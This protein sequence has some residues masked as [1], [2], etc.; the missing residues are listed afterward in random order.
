MTKLFFYT[1]THTHTKMSTNDVYQSPYSTA[2]TILDCQKP[3]AGY[4][5]GYFSNKPITGKSW[6]DC[7]NRSYSAFALE[8]QYNGYYDECFNWGNC[9]PACD[10]KY[11]NAPPK[12]VLGC[13]DQCCESSDIGLINCDKDCQIKCVTTKP[14]PIFPILPQILPQILSKNKQ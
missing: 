9:K 10:L 3:G 2:A 13:W 8:S 1:Q 14:T 6:S 12:K 5:P 7:D 4:S 11:V